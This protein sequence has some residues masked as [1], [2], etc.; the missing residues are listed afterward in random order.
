[1]ESIQQYRCA[2]GTFS[3]NNPIKSKNSSSL[4]EPKVSKWALFFIVLILSSQIC[5]NYKKS[6]QK[7]NNKNNHTIF[8]N[9]KNGC[10]KLVHWNKG[11]S[12]F[13]NKIDY[14]FSTIDSHK[15][16]IFSLVL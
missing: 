3:H 8:G 1:M 5:S 4:I 6:K 13:N 11:N 16:D 7:S 14:I 9:I 15:P 10:Y 2:I 12:N